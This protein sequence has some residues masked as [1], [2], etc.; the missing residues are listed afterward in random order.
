M[1][2]EAKTPPEVLAQL[3]HNLAEHFSDEELRVLC[4]DLRV[5]YHELPGE[6]KSVKVVELISYLERRDRLSELVRKCSELRPNVAWPLKVLPEAATPAPAAILRRQVRFFICYKRHADPDQKLAV[7]LHDCLTAQGHDVFIDGTMRT[8]VAW[9]DEIDRQ[10]EASNFL[11]VLLSK[12]SA[13]SEMVQSEVSRAYEYRRLQGH[14]RIL[15]VR[16]AY[17]GLLPYTIAAFLNPLQYVVWQSEAD[18]ERVGRDILDAIQG[19]LPVRSPIQIELAA[20]RVIVSEGG[21]RI[22]DDGALH[23]PLPEF[24]PRFLEVNDDTP[25]NSPRVCRPGIADNWRGHTGS[26]A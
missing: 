6:A 26:G 14:P 10:I 16:I 1:A 3:R 13:D 2:Q 17:E 9:L 8:G 15:P 18:D 21:R 23:P 19:R 5:D 22:A 4:F 25:N 11:I 20:G 12:S 24:D 7:Y